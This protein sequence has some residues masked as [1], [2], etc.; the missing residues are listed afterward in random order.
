MA[1]SSCHELRKQL[2]SEEGLFTE[3]Q[4]YFQQSFLKSMRTGPFFALTSQQANKVNESLPTIDVDGVTK[5]EKIP[6]NK[7]D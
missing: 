6:R 7:C 3:I 1:L 4:I 2:L 5:M